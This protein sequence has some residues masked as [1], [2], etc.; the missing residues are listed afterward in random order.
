M[1]CMGGPKVNKFEKVSS[2]GHQMSLGGGLCT[3]KSHVLR[4]LGPG[5]GAGPRGSLYSGVQCIMG[6]CHMESLVDRMTD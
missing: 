3:V 4:G 2:N 1:L 6:N 5:L